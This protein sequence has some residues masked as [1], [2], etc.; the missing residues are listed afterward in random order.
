MKKI[1]ILSCLILFLVPTLT[2]LVWGQEKIETP[3]EWNVGDRWVY[4]DQDDKTITLR[5]IGLEEVNGVPH[6]VVQRGVNKIY[7]TKDIRRHLTKRATGNGK[8][9]SKWEPTLFLFSWPL[10]V[11]KKW[12]EKLKLHLLEKGDRWNVRR[13]SKVVGIEE[14]EVPAGKFRTFH[15]YATETV[16]YM[17]DFHFWYSPEVGYVVKEKGYQMG[18]PYE[19]KLLEYY[20]EK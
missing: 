11:G 7:F 10:E 16:D 9:I 20:R 4:K 8:I 15:I 14:I 2:P 17:V 1:L 3:P 5:V 13:E 19:L 18:E 6:Y 12:K